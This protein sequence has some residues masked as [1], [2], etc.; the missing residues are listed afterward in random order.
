MGRVV[1]INEKLDSK[2]V[3][4][5]WHLVCASYTCRLK[6]V[7]VNGQLH[8]SLRGGFEE[9]WTLAGADGEHAFNELQSLC[10]VDV[11]ESHHGGRALVVDVDDGDGA[12]VSNLPALSLDFSEC[13]MELL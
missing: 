9:D 1:Y 4:K 12:L 6:R 7:G 3:G 13:E 8:P 2:H 11:L 5:R 10:S